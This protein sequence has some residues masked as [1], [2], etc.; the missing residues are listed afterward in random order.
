[1]LRRKLFYNMFH[2][3]ECHFLTYYPFRIPS[4]ISRVIEIVVNN[5]FFTTLSLSLM[6]PLTPSLLG[7]WSLSLAIS[8]FFTLNN[9]AY[10]HVTLN[11]RHKNLF[12]M[13]HVYDIY[14]SGF[15]FFFIRSSMSDFT[16]VALMD[17]V[18]SASSLSC[19]QH[20]FLLWQPACC[21]FNVWSYAHNL[22]LPSL[23]FHTQVIMFVIFLS[24]LFLI[25]FLRDWSQLTRLFVFHSLFSSYVHTNVSLL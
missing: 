25:S 12:S 18:L 4:N 24:L 9:S 5:H 1:M 8:V 3:Q 7:N 17:K 16:N 21:H 10:N 15:L 2:L 14:V 6:T 13:L 23:T 20:F 22:L 19:R 11:V